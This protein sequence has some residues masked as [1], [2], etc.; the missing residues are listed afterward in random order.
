MKTKAAHLGLPC[1]VRFMPTVL[2]I[3]NNTILFHAQSELNIMLYLLNEYAFNSPELLS[4][5]AMSSAEW[6][7][8]REATS[9][10]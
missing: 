5:P 2:L 1:T 9:F 10:A 8:V 4:G 6:P 7:W 3:V